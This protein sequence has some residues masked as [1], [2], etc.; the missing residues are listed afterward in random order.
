MKQNHYIFFLVVFAAVFACNRSTQKIA[1]KTDVDQDNT[2]LQ[3]TRD[4]TD[5]LS[6]YSQELPPPIIIT[7]LD[8]IRTLDWNSGIINKDTSF[9]YPIKGGQYGRYYLI[10]RFHASNSQD[11]SKVLVGEIVIFRKTGKLWTVNDTTQKFQNIT[12]RSNIIAVWDS[13]YVGLN[14]EKLIDF[15]GRNFHY[16]KGAILH[17]EFDNYY[18]DFTIIGDTIQK[19][20]ISRR[21][22]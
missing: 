21:C 19:I 8:E 14:K 12:L 15:I 10:D 18:G 13:I 20:Y 9:C 3:V 1:Q 4:S 6:N 11:I 17:A 5:T 22:D 16:Q 2:E 7:D